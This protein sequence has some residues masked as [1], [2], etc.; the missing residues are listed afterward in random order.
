MDNKTNKYIAAQ[1]KLYDVTDGK[2]ELVE[3]TTDNLSLIHI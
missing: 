1:Y 2:S 3:E